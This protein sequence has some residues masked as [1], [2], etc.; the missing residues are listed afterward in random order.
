MHYVVQFYPEHQLKHSMCAE[1]QKRTVTEIQTRPQIGI[2]GGLM[3]LKGTYRYLF[4]A[5]YL[6]K[7]AEL[8]A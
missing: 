3:R 2:W 5:V 8:C 6:E 4:K 1:G 7:V